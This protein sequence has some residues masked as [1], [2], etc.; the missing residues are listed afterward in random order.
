[1]GEACALP[2]V[3]I[4]VENLSKAIS[5]NHAPLLCMEGFTAQYNFSEIDRLAIDQGKEQFLSEQVVYLKRR[6]Y[7]VGSS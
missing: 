1:M 4:C 2:S 5:I 3:L 7:C 6:Q